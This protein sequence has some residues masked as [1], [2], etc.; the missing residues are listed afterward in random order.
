MSRIVFLVFIF[1]LNINVIRPDSFQTKVSSEFLDSRET[2]DFVEL[3]PEE[4]DK[5]FYSLTDSENL[6]WQ[7]I[8][9]QQLAT[10]SNDPENT[11][12]EV[13]DQAAR[14]INADI[15]RRMLEPRRAI[16][17]AIARLGNDS[18]EYVLEAYTAFRW[19]RMD[20]GNRVKVLRTILNVYTFKTRMY[21]Y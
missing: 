10:Y 15:A 14:S 11:T 6:I 19:M 5:F 13:L 4:V 21:S 20:M 8:Y 12:F 17:D 16:M 9:L 3:L 18:A 2:Y 7:T 1:H